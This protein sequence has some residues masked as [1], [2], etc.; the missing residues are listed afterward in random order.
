MT[1]D[2]NFFNNNIVISNN[3]QIP[4]ASLYCYNNSSVRFKFTNNNKQ[5]QIYGDNIDGLVLEG[6]ENATF[7]SRPQIHLIG[8]LDMLYGMRMREF[9]S[10]GLIRSNIELGYLVPNKETDAGKIEYNASTQR[11]VINGAGNS[12]NNKTVEIKDNLVVNNTNTV[13]GSSQFNGKAVFMSNNFFNGQVYLNNT[14]TITGQ[15]T[16]NGQADFNGPVFLNTNTVSGLST[17][18]GQANFNS[19]AVFLQTVTFSNPVYLYNKTKLELR[20]ATYAGSRAN[21]AQIFNDGHMLF[22]WD[23]G[24]QQLQWSPQQYGGWFDA[25]IHMTKYGAQNSSLNSMDD[26]STDVGKYYYF[27]NGGAIDLN[28]NCGAYGNFIDYYVI[29]ESNSFSD[30]G[31][32]IRVIT[33]S[34]NVMKIVVESIL[35]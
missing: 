15:T 14:N 31:Y 32:H 12:V 30:P 8:D 16:F 21:T 35:S 10:G 23:G 17:F 6:I 2:L 13:L 29:N 26:I 11:L 33:G 19:D 25:G 9:I 24:N 20:L 7:P 3:G 28:F 18:N 22:N 5:G 34:S 27:T 4:Y 1:G